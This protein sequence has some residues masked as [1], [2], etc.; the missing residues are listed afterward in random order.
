M[1]HRTIQIALVGT[2]PPTACGIA[3]FTDSLR[4]ALLGRGTAVDSRSRNTNVSADV[5]RLVVAPTTDRADGVVAEWVRGD[6][7]SLL[8]AVR[9]AN[10]HDCVVVQH[11][12]GVYGGTDGEDVVEF[13]ESC[14]VPV[15]VVLHTVMPAPTAKQREIVERIVSAADFAVVQTVAARR[16][17]LA[18]HSVDSE[19]VVVIP[20]GAA[21]NFDGPVLDLGIDGPI[22]LT[23]GLIG[24][25]KGIE[26][27][28][29]AVALLTARTIPTPT[30]LVAGRTHPNVLAHEGE[31]Y[32]HQLVTLAEDLG[33]KDNVVL[34]ASYRDW[35]S[36]RAMIRG[37]DVVVLPYDNRDQVT[38]GVLVE[39][40]AS[41]R[42]VVATA[43]PH[44]LEALG[45]GAGVVVPHENPLAIADTLE[46]VLNDPERRTQMQD[47]ARA[48]AAV[49]LWPRVGQEYLALAYAATRT[50]AAA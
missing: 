12:F 8:T 28:I 14:L 2:Y 16:R 37:A 30:Y 46:R 3:T 18:N 22:V 42:A 23:W 27:V 39:A 6:P 21:A 45:S 40:L 49:L 47:I 10:E 35:D 1:R 41:G 9:A 48:E 15:I 13:V 7:G 24:P 11:E 19:R 43:F 25:G 38:S 34:D 50:M 31:R 32:R 5:I 29:R 36:L 17:L 44:A 33:V 20:H 4:R 26:H